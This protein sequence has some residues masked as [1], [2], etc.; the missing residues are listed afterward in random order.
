MSEEDVFGPYIGNNE[1]SIFQT[2]KNLKKTSIPLVAKL[3]GGGVSGSSTLAG[4]EEA[5]SKLRCN[6]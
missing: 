4:N 5:L 3:S 1:N 2:N 6:F